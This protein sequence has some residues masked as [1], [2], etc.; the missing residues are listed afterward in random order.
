MQ[1]GTVISFDNTIDDNIYIVFFTFFQCLYIF[2]K[3]H[4]TIYTDTDIALLAKVLKQIL[5]CS[6]FPVYGRRQDGQT[7]FIL[8]FHDAVHHL[9]NC[10]GCDGL[11]VRRTVRNTDSRI[12]K[13]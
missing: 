7:G 2:Q 1:T 9:L 13:S 4:L 11:V 5:V 6:L 3:L 10:L 8:N 12:Q